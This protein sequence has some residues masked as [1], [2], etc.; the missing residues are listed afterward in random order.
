VGSLKW[1]SVKCHEDRNDP[2]DMSKCYV[3]PSLVDHRLHLEVRMGGEPDLNDPELQSSPQVDIDSAER[4]DADKPA[5]GEWTPWI[6][7]VFA[8]RQ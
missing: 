7:Y 1:L 2:G 4:C 8:R 6:T 5:R 3:R